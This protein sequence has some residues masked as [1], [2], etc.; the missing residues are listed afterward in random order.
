MKKIRLEKIIPLIFAVIF[1]CT[2]I[3][4][5]V[6]ERN[7]ANEYSPRTV[8]FNSTFE[9]FD[10]ICTIS[11]YGKLNESDAEKCIANIKELLYRYDKM[12]SR[13]NEESE[14]YKINHRQS[15][16]I[17]TYS[18]VA[19]LFKISK[20]F[21]MWSGE[22]F[23][24]SGGTLYELWDIK[25][26]K[27]L[28]LQTEIEEALKHIGNFDYDVEIVDDDTAQSKITFYGD[29]KTIYDFG[30][31]VKG[32]VCVAIKKL[33]EE[34]ENVKAALISL[35][36][37][38]YCYGKLI[39][40]EGGNFRVGIY[41]PFSNGELADTISVHDTCVITSGNYERYFKVKGDDRI[42]HHIISPY[43]GYPTN[44]GIDSVT[45][46]SESGL[47]GDY[48]STAV[49]ILGEKKGIELIKKCKEELKIEIDVIFIYS[50][51]KIVKPFA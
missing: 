11:I 29:K 35:G 8:P 4:C 30:A 51:G 42:Y 33:L 41:K 21:Y 13:T 16:E 40:R 48:L 28:P 5:N 12:F 27:E 10:T 31:L 39:D 44:N 37:N 2:T 25:N 18:E 7:K 36:G 3:S 22:A 45:I 50:D 20:D 17:Y 43:D 1:I 32:Y 14:I 19:N 38:V 46:I 23:D 47:L 6:R 15:D 34:D 49:M 9:A 26:R 24:V